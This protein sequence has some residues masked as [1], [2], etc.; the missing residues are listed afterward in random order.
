MPVLAQDAA[1]PAP[2]A[3]TQE[4]RQHAVENMS[5]LMTALN[6]EAVDQDV[7]NAL[8][9]CIYGNSMRDITIAMDKAIAANPERF[10]RTDSGV[11]LGVMASICGYQPPAAQQGQEAPAQPR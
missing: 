1:A 11:M 6:S 8:M 9:S 4:T 5:L 2:S 10:D 3:D 7:K